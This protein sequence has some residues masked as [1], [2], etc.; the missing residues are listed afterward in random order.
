MRITNSGNNPIPTSAADAKSAETAK[1]RGAGRSHE[2]SRGERPEGA[3]PTDGAKPEIS[4]RG[5]EFANAKAIAGSAPDV[6][7]EKI[8]ALKRRIA[9]GSYN[10]DSDAVADRMVNDHLQMGIG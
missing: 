9:E 5:R 4:A 1:T 3:A 7:E 10:V 6:R 2:T 8:A